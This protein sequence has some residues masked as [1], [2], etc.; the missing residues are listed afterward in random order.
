MKK[1][2]VLV[3]ILSVTTPVM[4]RD[5]TLVK[6]R[7]DSGGFG[8]PVVKFAQ[9]NGE[10]ALLVGGRGGWIIDHSFVI[11]GGGYGLV[12]NIRVDRLDDGSAPRFDLGYGG[13]EMEYVHHSRKLMHFT[14]C[15]LIGAGSVK[16]RDEDLWDLLF[17]DSEDVFFIAEPSANLMLNVTTYFRVGIGASYR[18]VTGIELEGLD[19]GD[20][21]GPSANLLMKFG[22]F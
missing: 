20:L 14:I 12:N 18:F 11:G 1:L 22:D 8:A 16:Y 4:A 7:I 5:E 19:E 13:F 2:V 9:M 10:F 15:A 17:D 21:S 6:G 3:L